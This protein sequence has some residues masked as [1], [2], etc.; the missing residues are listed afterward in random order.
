MKLLLFYLTLAL[1]ISFLCSI[2]E[3][4]IL[5]V[6]APYIKMKEMEG[7]ASAK[8]LK[9]LKNKIDRPLS[10]ILTINTVAHTIGA[11]GVGAQA[12]AVFGEVYFG[13]ISAI[14]TILILFFS[15]IIPKTIG[16]VFWRKLALPSA[17]V[18]IGMIYISY[19]LVVIS[20]FITKFISK[21]KEF[22]RMSREEIVASVH[23]GTKE[24]VLKESESKIINNLIRLK[25][26]NA[27]AIMTPRTVVVSAPEEIS[28]DDFIKQ[29]EYLQYSRIP[30]YS[31]NIDNVTGY[32]LNSDVLEKL[33]NHSINQ[34]LKDLKR[35]IIIFYENFSIPK[36]FEELLLKKEHIALVINEYGGMQGLI[37][38]EDIIETILGLEIMDEKDIEVNMQELAKKKW[39]IRKKN[40]NI[41]KD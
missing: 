27:R 26:I 21:N 3:A 19:P 7:K 31:G 16:A 6:S 39:K 38:M 33:A 24:G 11:A 4:V 12:V 8:H 22:K 9:N 14:L 41:D 2:V 30:V 17:I 34:E 23:L 36:L 10:A 18:I 20:E 15:E 25:T 28:L 40:L 37:T 1:T 13:V 5:S 32:I 35:P 29:K